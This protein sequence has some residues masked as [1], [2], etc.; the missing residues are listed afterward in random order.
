MRMVQSAGIGTYLQELVPRLFTILSKPALCLLG[1]PELL[2]GF[3]WAQHPN[4]RIIDC[5]A[6][7]Y[8]LREQVEL[9]MRIPRDT[10]LYWSPHYNIPLSYRGSLLVTV[11]DT[12]HL[13][14]PQF[15]EG[16]HRRAYARLMFR[17]VRAKATAIVCVSQFAKDQLLQF[18]PKGR[19]DV[20]VVY[21]GVDASWFT[22]VP[23]GSPHGK[24]YMLFVG[25]VKPHKNLSR[26]LE[27]FAFVQEH[28]PHDLVI[29]GRRE[30]FITGD[31]SAMAMASAMSDRVICVGELEHGDELLRRYYRYA[32]VL[33]MPSLYESFGLPAL[34]ALACGCPVI[35][36]R[37]A[38]LPEVYGEGAMYCDPYDPSDMAERIRLMVSNRGVRQQYLTAGHA[39]ATHYDW[40]TT[41]EQL[42]ALVRAVRVS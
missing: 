18:V 1:H 21:N 42:A 32:D 24:P 9:P 36:S 39:V 17:A 40:D 37:V 20:T 26:L 29:I 19:Q 3:T 41:A 27:A 22:P 14:M 7:I 6:G 35:V 4:I 13:A 33:V 25:S 12:F 8:S 34:E 16:W 11:H 30:G 28:I 31:A 5:R 38:G 15:V 10:T 2:R 23:G